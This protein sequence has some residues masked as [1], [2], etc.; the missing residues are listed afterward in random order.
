[1]ECQGEGPQDGPGGGGDEAGRRWRRTCPWKRGVPDHRGGPGGLAPSRP[2]GTDGT[3][4][5]V[6][7]AAWGLPTLDRPAPLS[8]KPT[9][10]W[11]AASGERQAAASLSVRDRVEREAQVDQEGVHATARSNSSARVKG[12]DGGCGMA[13]GDDFPDIP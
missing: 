3:K 10:S 5:V 8:V 13:V 4:R 11:F 6:E 1:M 2:R 12:Q 7:G 9:E